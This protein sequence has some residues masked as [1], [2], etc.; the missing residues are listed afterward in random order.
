MV[1]RIHTKL[2][3]LVLER[4]ATKAHRGTW[5]D[6]DSFLSEEPETLQDVVWSDLQKRSGILTVETKVHGLGSRVI[7]KISLKHTP[8]EA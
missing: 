3:Y 1:S 6:S 5:V 4:K 8:M 2:S 7:N